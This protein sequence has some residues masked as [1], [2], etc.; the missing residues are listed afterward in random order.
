MAT[1]RG[2]D[3][4][5]EAHRHHPNNICNNNASPRGHQA[6]IL[7]AHLYPRDLIRG[8]HRPAHTALEIPHR[9]FIRTVLDLLRLST[10]IHIAHNLLPVLRGSRCTNSLQPK[11][12]LNT[13]EIHQL[14]RRLSDTRLTAQPPL[15]Q[16]LRVESCQNDMTSDP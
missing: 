11:F 6:A 4:Y 13:K 12:Q 5:Q 3:Q 1:I 8:G 10:L 15:E 2:R 9:G 7:Q 14:L 16:R